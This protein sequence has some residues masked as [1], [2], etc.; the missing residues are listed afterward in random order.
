VAAG[1]GGGAVSGL[2]GA[3]VA[4]RRVGALLVRLTRCA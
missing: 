2:A 4:A 3:A 1:A